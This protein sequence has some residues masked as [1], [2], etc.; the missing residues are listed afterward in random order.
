MSARQRRVGENASRVPA[1]RPAATPA[2]ASPGDT[3]RIA[4]LILC[5]LLPIYILNFRMLGVG[6][7]M[8]TRVL[9]FSVLREGNLNLDEFTWGRRSD[10]Q[11]PYYVHQWGEHIY[12]VS[13]IGTAL[14][15]TPLYILPAWWVDA[16]ALD[17]DD[18]RVRVLFVV[19]ERISAALL[20]AL[21]ATV[22]FVVLSRLATRRWAVA[23]TLVYGLGTSTWSI[24]SQALWPH[25]LSELCLILLTAILLR[26]APSR[27]AWV[28]AG[29][30]I[31][32]MLANRPQMVVFA[33]PA[34]LYVFLE[35]RRHLLE[36]IALP[37]AAG[38]LVI[39]YNR[40]RF[41]S[42]TGGYG[43]FE[44]FS[45]S[46]PDGVLGLL[47]SP[48]RGLFIYTPIML[49]AAVGAVRVWR[50][51]APSWVRW[52]T[53]GVGLHLLLY[54]QFNEWWAGYA[55]G[56]RYFTDVLP[57]L[58]IFLVFGLVPL[59]RSRAVRLF[60]ATC[61]VFG[62]AIQAIGVYCADDTWN[63]EPVPLELQPERV[64]D[65]NDL[66]ITRALRNGWRGGELA[67]VMFDAFRDPLP[68]RV[69]PLVQDDLAS[70]IEA[71]DFPAAMRR[72]A[73]AAGSL[74]ITNRG[75]AT[76]PA[77]SGEGV[78][79]SRY[80]VFVLTR[81]F[82]NGRLVDGVGDVALLPVNLAPGETIEMPLSV[83]APP[84]AGDF[85]LELRVSQAVDRARGLVGHDALRLPVHVE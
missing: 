10:G 46:L 35:H 25:A 64:W 83:I 31:A 71:R 74:E 55:Y 50:A 15:I 44:H 73:T 47:V 2:P 62:F 82:M 77:F 79:S 11:L 7:S 43:G 45:G 41:A 16:N 6:D 40:S 85:E 13:T 4:L 72:G 26:P 81:W 19:M 68:A 14:A 59:W 66:Q 63:R 57:A 49:F 21:S 75:A 76:W 17:Y 52:L 18:V 22:L 9:P 78:M 67:Q 51:A 34:V 30:I 53:I 60:A 20:T 1:T 29:V 48:N 61:I 36:M 23:L 56:P 27:W 65:W 84:S 69:E 8:A 54:A 58:T 70:A 12:A 42:L 24:A 3:W 33:A 28:T 37:A 38:A 32:V 5:G 80:L 39:A